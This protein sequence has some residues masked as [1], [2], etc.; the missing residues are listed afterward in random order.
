M[1]PCQ[2]D[3]ASSNRELEHWVVPHGQDGASEIWATCSVR[4]TDGIF[5][6]VLCDLVEA[7]VTQSHSFRAAAV[8]M[9]LHCGGC[10]APTS[11][12]VVIKLL[13]REHRDCVMV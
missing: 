10:T 12:F 9:S 6:A 8:T 7:L 3:S 2:G 5:G 1:L 11:T 4:G 13:N